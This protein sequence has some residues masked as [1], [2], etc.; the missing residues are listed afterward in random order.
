MEDLVAV[1]PLVCAL[2]LVKG[3]LITVL[4][5]MPSEAQERELDTG[6]DDAEQAVFCQQVSGEI[7]FQAIA[8]ESR[9]HAILEAAREH[10]IVVMATGARR[11]LKRLFFGSL[12]E[13]IALRIDRP[14]L[15]VSPGAQ[16]QAPQ[17]TGSPAAKHRQGQR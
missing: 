9:A 7:T 3:H 6:R 8:A 11:G 17:E 1:R 2:A 15:I 14:M 10:D 16:A 5:L 12:A 4:R 13:D